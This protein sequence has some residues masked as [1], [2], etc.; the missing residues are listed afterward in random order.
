MA[1]KGRN[2]EKEKYGNRPSPPFKANEYCGQK[3]KGNDG[4]MY[5][6]KPIKNGSHCRWVRA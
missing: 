3:K 5:I 1:K 4:K 6:S 2:F